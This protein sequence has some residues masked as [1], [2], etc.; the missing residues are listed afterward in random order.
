MSETKVAVPTRMECDCCGSAVEGIWEVPASMLGKRRCPDA[1]G[2]VRG[3]AEKAS[4]AGWLV[5]GT[6]ALC[7]ECLAAA[8]EDGEAPLPPPSSAAQAIDQLALARAVRKL[9]KGAG[10]GGSDL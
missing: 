6:A 10:R 3:L 4:G 8:V 2:A 5:R 9:R 7:P 1:T